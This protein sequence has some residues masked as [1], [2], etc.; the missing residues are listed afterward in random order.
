M[1]EEY[2]YVDGKVIV[3][4]NWNRQE[5][6]EYRDNLE[7][8]LIQENLIELME[9]EEERLNEKYIETTKKIKGDK[10][11]NILKKIIRPYVIIA[12]YVLL[13]TFVFDLTIPW[14]FNV[15]HFPNF[16]SFVNITAFIFGSLLC[17]P[18]IIS[19]YG[20]Y[21]QAIKEKKVLKIN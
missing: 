19:D 15:S 21:I 6:V 4:D 18:F 13:I 10:K 3:R 2:T 16:K 9:N 20:N 5:L 8:V 11:T 1:N 7:E 14:V 12:I 17:T